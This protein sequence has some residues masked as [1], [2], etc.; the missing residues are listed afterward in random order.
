MGPDMGDDETEPPELAGLEQWA[1]EARAREAA[2]A[3]ARE[4]WLRTQAEEEARLAAV[5]IGMAE[6]GTAVA[7]STTDSRHLTGRITRV[8]D[9]FVAIEAT[10]GRVTLVALHALAWCRPAQS[11]RRRPDPA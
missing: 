5:L 3:R 6:R 8:G 10:G 9:D 1:A 2:E 4:R 11:D 7:A